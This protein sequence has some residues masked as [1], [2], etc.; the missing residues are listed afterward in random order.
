MILFFIQHHF[1][2]LK[3]FCPEVSQ[4]VGK[5]NVDQ[6]PNLGIV[7]GSSPIWVPGNLISPVSQV[8]SQM[9]NFGRVPATKV[10]IYILNLKLYHLTSHHHSPNTSISCCYLLLSSSYPPRLPPWHLPPHWSRQLCQSPGLD[11][12]DFPMTW[13]SRRDMVTPCA[14]L[15]KRSCSVHVPPWYNRIWRKFAE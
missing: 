13:Q 1:V 4:V 3:L 11:K 7:F 10:H 5:K 12:T 2:S 14:L 8:L 15:A 6:P 9:H